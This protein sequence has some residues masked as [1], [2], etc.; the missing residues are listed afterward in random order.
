MDLFFLKR[1]ISILAPDAKFKKS[2]GATPSVN[3]YEL[4]L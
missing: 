3:V 2:K 1:Q 4:A